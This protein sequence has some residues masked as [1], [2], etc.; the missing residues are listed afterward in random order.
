MKCQQI[1]VWLLAN[2]ALTGGTSQALALAQ[3]YNAQGWSVILEGGLGTLSAPPGVTLHQLAAQC[4]CCVGQLPLRVT[5]ARII[6]LEKPQRLI[7]EITHTEHLAQIAALLRSGSFGE[8]L[9]LES[10]PE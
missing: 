7:L 9:C 3:R 6:R 5:L 4:V 8:H 2:P 1:P 10:V